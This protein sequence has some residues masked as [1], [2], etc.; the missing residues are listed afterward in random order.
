[1]VHRVLRKKG[2]RVLIKGD[3]CTTADGWIPTENLLGIVTRV[4]RKGK[5]RF[6][7]DR[8]QL[9]PWSSTYLFIYPLWPPV[10]RLLAKSWR[11]MRT[12]IRQEN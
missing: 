3:N 9:H 2:D 6:W 1:L 8:S 11:C 7:P 12:I 4:E 10:R 5:K